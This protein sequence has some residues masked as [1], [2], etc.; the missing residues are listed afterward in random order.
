MSA[1]EREAILRLIPHAG[2]M[3]LLDAAEKWNDSEITCLSARYALA[4]NPL[5]RADGSLG[6]SCLI[7]I[8]AQAMA[9]HGRLCAAD[10]APPRPGLLVSL[11]ETVLHSAM[12][13]GTD[14]VLTVSARRLMGDARGASYAFAVRAAGRML[15]EGRAMVL[16]AVAA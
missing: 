6:A 13:D 2:A 3:C 1:L 11:R 15:A 8:A 5:R 10:G 14:G 7:E 9:L 12:L 4:D 16:F